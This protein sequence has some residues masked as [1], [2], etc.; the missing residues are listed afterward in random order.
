[1]IPS[2]VA[3]QVR[4]T[5]LDYL[6][7]TFDLADEEFSRSL[8]AF[9][10]GPEGLFKGPYIDVRL[11]F[12]KAHADERV[13]LD[14][15][16]SFTPYKHQL[17]A[18]RRLYSRDGHQPQHTLVTTGTGSGK[19]EC[20]LFPIVDHC[21][22]LHQQPGIKAIILYPMN[23]LAADQARRLAKMLWDDSR[24]RGVV[25]AGLYV[26][27]NGSYGAADAEHLIDQRDVLRKSPPDILLTNYKML[28]F[29]LLRPEDNPLWK[30]NVAGTLRYLV[31]DE[32]HTYDG[33]QGSDVA[34][35]IRRLK[36]RLAIAPGDLCCV[37]T[38]AT[39]GGDTRGESLRKLTE[40]AG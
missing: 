35:L 2:V 39:L 27:G 13:P 22:R 28:D 11:P 4:D 10:D 19:T 16:P 8:F 15:R 40:F 37:G 24:L 38:S 30:H 12:R 33:A 34:C 3:R 9:L 29:L 21:L 32:L 1:M 5:I 36:N 7:T 6:G 23:A 25:S 31:L 14:V 26:G 20:F 17:K 18:F